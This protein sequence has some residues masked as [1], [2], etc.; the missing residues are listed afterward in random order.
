MRLGRE[1]SAPPAIG[2]WIDG[3]LMALWTAR[4]IHIGSTLKTCPIYQSVWYMNEK[5]A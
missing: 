3:P 2:S 5:V 4:Q 1:H